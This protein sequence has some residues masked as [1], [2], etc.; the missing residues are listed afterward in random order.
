MWGRRLAAIL[1]LALVVVTW[2]VVFDRA[3]WQAADVFTRDNIER[4]QRGEPLPT[5]AAAYRPHVRQAALLASA[6]ASGVFVLGAVVLN[7][8]GRLRAMPPRPD[9]S[10]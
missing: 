8:A 5:L 4:H 2:N 9:V 6:W 7:A 1:W 10:P 3:V